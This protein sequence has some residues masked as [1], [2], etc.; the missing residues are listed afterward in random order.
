MSRRS[1]RAR[2]PKVNKNTHWHVRVTIIDDAR[3]ALHCERVGC[4]KSAFIRQAVEE[5]LKRDEQS[6]G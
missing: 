6:D 5:K 2:V 4:E 1:T 3:L